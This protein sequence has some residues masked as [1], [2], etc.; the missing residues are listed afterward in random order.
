MFNYEILYETGVKAIQ[1]L[2]LNSIPDVWRKKKSWSGR[3]NKR[4]NS[5]PPLSL[6]SI[7]FLFTISIMVAPLAVLYFTMPSKTACITLVS[8]V[9]LIWIGQELVF[10]EAWTR[11]AISVQKTACMAATR[12][13]WVTTSNRQRN[14]KYLPLA[15]AGSNQ[16]QPVLLSS[17]YFFYY[18]S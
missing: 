17:L 9:T 10:R 12:V 5:L 14:G 15:K 3:R 7:Y 13:K 1:T 16:H 4:G 18:F 6:S 8:I 11:K 2:S